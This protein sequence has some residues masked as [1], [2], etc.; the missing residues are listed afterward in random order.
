MKKIKLIIGLGL[1]GYMAFAQAPAS[2]TFQGKADT[3]FNGQEIVIYN[4]S[5]GLMDSTTVLNGKFN[6]KALYK[7][8]GRYMFYSKYEYQKKHGYAPFGIL[9]T[10]GA[11][12]MFNADMANLAN[13]EVGNAP[14]TKLYND[15]AKVSSGNRKKITDQAN[16]KFGAEFLK[17]LSTKDAGYPEVA[18]FYAGLNKE[19]TIAESKRLDAFIKQHPDSFAAIYLLQSLV[20]NLTAAEGQ[21]LYDQ[22][23]PKYK[24][25]I[26]AVNI[27]KSIK[28]RDITELGKIAPDFEQPDTS[29]N[30]V[31]LSSLRG[32]YVL[33]DFWASWCGPCRKE[34]PNVVN[35]YQKYHEKGFTVLGVSLDQPGKKDVWLKAIH[36]DQLTW[37]HVSDLKFWDNA[38]ARLYGIRSIPQ[39]YLLDKDGKII[40][41]N[42]RGEEL[43]K[44]LTAIF[45]E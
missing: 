40:A 10:N 30:L 32:K 34:N 12:V 41:T 4:K 20:A 27:A 22:I 36:Q 19:N 44:K 26:Y 11:T 6:F 14:E 35:A 1:F 5:I 25:T 37:T 28:A 31:K 33:I 23:G 38:V 17:T 2:I 16:E 43:Q 3:A 45:G 15:F 13:S 21:A 24:N 39:N 7:E 8:P 18:K 9:V 29:G 42:I